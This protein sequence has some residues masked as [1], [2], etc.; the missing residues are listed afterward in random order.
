MHQYF[1][2]YVK[3]LKKK[4]IFQHCL[5]VHIYFHFQERQVI[6]ASTFEDTSNLLKLNCS[7]KGSIHKAHFPWVYSPKIASKLTSIVTILTSISLAGEYIF[8]VLAQY[9]RVLPQYL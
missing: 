8:Q 3:T 6:V 1:E 9:L 4:N 7:E 5:K 2:F